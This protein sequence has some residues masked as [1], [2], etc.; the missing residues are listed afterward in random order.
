MYRSVHNYF[1]L[2][3]F[4]FNV[5]GGFLFFVFFSTFVS[6]RLRDI[7]AIPESGSAG[8]VFLFFTVTHFP[9]HAKDGDLK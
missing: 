6:T 8:G 2:F 5:A 3:F 9:V 1:S 4:S 7:V